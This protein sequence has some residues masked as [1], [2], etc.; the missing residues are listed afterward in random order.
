MACK[1]LQEVL[2]ANRVLSTA[3][4]TEHMHQAG[5]GAEYD[6]DELRSQQDAAVVAVLLS[7]ED[8]C[9]PALLNLSAR[10]QLSQLARQLLQ[11]FKPPQQTR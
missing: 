5:I 9:V 1:R 8:R 7:E 4:C 11:L 10:L 3:L 6:A 2:D